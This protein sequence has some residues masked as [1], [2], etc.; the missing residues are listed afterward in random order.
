MCDGHTY[1]F[2]IITE[3]DYTQMDSKV[4][5]WCRDCGGVVVDRDYDGRTNPGAIMGM[6]FPSYKFD[7]K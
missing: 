1:N 7:K 2:I 5:R 4:V 3:Y 6:I